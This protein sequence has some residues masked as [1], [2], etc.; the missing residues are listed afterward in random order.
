MRELAVQASNDTNDASDRTNLQLELEQLVAEIDRI[1]AATQLAG[2]DLLNGGGGNSKSF[3][4]QIGA[5]AVNNVD[6]L[7]VTVKTLSSSNTQIMAN[8]GGNQTIADLKSTAMAGTVPAFTIAYKEADGTAP[9][10]NDDVITDSNSDNKPDNGIIQITVDDSAST[11]LDYAVITFNAGASDAYKITV[12][13][14]S[15]S[16]VSAVA[17]AF[18]NANPILRWTH[19]T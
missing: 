4:L 7:S 5:S 16:T 12:D 19:L 11:T 13:L 8:S 17:T 15:A 6:N 3:N 1:S 9:T 14:S 2:Q 10:N 18:S